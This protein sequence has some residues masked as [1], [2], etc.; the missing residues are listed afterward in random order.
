MSRGRLQGKT[1]LVT[2]AAAGIGRAIVDSFLN[3][4]A[5]VAVTDINQAGLADLAARGA[6]A[7]PQDVTDEARWREVVDA[8]VAAFGKLDILVN[9]AGIGIIGHIEKATLADFRKTQAVNVE[10]VFLG[11]RE[12]VRVMKAHGGSIVNI[13][14]VAGIIGDANSAAYCASKGAVRLLTKSVALHCARAGYGIRC[15][16][17]HPSFTETAMV[18]SFIATARDPDR[19]REGLRRAIPLGRL[20]QVHEIAAAV[21]YL[22]SDE[23]SFTTGAE[24]AVDGG[25]TA[26]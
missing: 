20:G 22:A 25:L 12:A 19:F 24:L 8:T 4:G 16:S 2:G 7:L 9:N 17:V 14:S 6:L 10:S 23:A 21:L 1:A 18:D 13:S 26:Q 5:R 11:C 15:N 3:E